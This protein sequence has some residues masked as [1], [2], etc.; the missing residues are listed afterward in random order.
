M[1]TSGGA[2]YSRWQGLSITRWREDPVVASHGSWLYLTDRLSG[3]VWSATLAPRGGS[4]TGYTAT[5]GE[6]RAEFRRRDGSLAT[7][8]EVLIYPR[9]TPRSAGCRS[10]IVVPRPAIST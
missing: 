6:G 3:E 8:T 9:M 7:T 4:P 5:F 1:L 10:S 2:G